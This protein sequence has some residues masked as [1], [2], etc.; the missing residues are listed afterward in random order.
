MSY[1]QSIKLAALGAAVVLPMVAASIEAAAEEVVVKLW[2]RADRSGPLRTGN[3]VA[4]AE[5]V[6]RRQIGYYHQD[7]RLRLPCI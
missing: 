6:I 5:P 2:S 7:C 1:P 4:A 3:I